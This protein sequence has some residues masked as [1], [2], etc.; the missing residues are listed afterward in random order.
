M[1]PFVLRALVRQP[2]LRL[3]RRHH[4]NALGVGWGASRFVP[5]PEILPAGARFRALYAAS[6]LTTAFAE[7]ALRADAVDCLDHHPIAV[8][9][10]GR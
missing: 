5:A 4:P 1:R 10:L 3:V 9:E 7:T 6:D 2:Y 8:E